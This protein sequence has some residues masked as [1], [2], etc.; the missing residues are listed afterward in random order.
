[1]RNRLLEQLQAIAAEH[2]PAVLA[3]RL[4]V[5]DMV[6]TDAI[7]G[8]RLPIEICIVDTGRLHADTLA[9][10]PQIE[11]RYGVPV[12]VVRPEAQQVE[13]FVAE[14]GRDAFYAS[15]ALRERCCELR[16]ARPLRRLL[17]GRRAWITGQ[18][19]EQLPGGAPLPEREFDTLHGLVR[20]N[21]LAAWNEGDVWR[22]VRAHRVPYNRLYEQGYRAIECAPCTAPRAGAWWWENRSHDS[23]SRSG[24]VIAIHAA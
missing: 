1:M 22:Y 21:P 4:S 11:S 24:K 5:E 12:G 17:A 10:I 8:A 18:R 9:L 3:S 6:V 15:V 13:H 19:R 7:A 2:S 14:H 23:A 16:K 20:F